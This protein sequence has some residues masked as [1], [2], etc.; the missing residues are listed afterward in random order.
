MFNTVKLKYFVILSLNQALQ[1][2]TPIQFKY[3]KIR[4]CLTSH[5]TKFLESFF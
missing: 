2:L 3:K 4:K 5:I 1:E